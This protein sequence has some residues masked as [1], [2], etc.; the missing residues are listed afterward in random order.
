MNRYHKKG[1]IILVIIPLLILLPIAVTV[2]SRSTISLSR[3][4]KESRL[5]ARNRNI[6]ASGLAWSRQN[7]EK[8]SGYEVNKEISV[9]I[10]SLG[11]EDGKCH[12]TVMNVKEELIEIELGVH[13]TRGSREIKRT[14]QHS[15]KR[16]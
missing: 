1:F 11:M 12:I 3:E 8:L 9:N 15:I 7:V 6:L 5:E 16:P 2:M 13:Y 14:R 4:L 10:N